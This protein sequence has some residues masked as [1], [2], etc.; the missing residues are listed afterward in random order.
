MSKEFEKFILGVRTERAA[1]ETK[2]RNDEA[3]KQ[4]AH[5]RRVTVFLEK[6]FDL[7]EH[8]VERMQAPDV[9]ELSAS[10][11]STAFGGNVTV[12]TVPFHGRPTQS[13]TLHAMLDENEDVVF[14]LKRD[15]EQR[16]E[17]REIIQ[18]D[19]VTQAVVDGLV[20]RLIRD[21]AVD[22]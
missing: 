9:Y 18:L 17:S 4:A 21:F 3:A 8:A 5:Q 16:G 20:L 10:S 22:P 2:R 19:A 13:A 12:K 11:G 6:V 1:A 14:R 7:L 15:G